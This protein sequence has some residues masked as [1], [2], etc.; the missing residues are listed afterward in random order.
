[1]NRRLEDLR[2]LIRARK[3]DA[4]MVSQSANRRYLSGFT[5][6]AGYLLISANEAVLATDFR[7]LEQAD[8]QAGGFRITRIA[9]DFTNWFP[10][11]VAEMG[12][13]RIGFESE[14]MTDDGYQQL[15]RAA[16]KVSPA[17]RPGL[18][19]TTGLVESLRMVKDLSEMESIAA[20]ARLADEAMEYAV[21]RVFSGMTEK[22]LAWELERFLRERG[23]EPVPFEIIVASG[24]NSARPH[25]RSSDRTIREGEPVVIDLG[26]RVEGY[27]SDLTRTICLGMPDETFRRVYEVVALARRK[28]VDGLRPGLTGG[29]ADALA[30]KVIE[31]AG[32]GE[33]FG[34]GLGHGVGLET[35]ES[36]R[37]GP[38]ARD[39]LSEGMVF[40]VEPGIYI[41]GWGGVRIEDMILLE[42]EGPRVLTRVGKSQIQEIR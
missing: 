32:H 25:A 24:P 23:S 16:R 33:D 15:V 31:D 10:R 39:I 34:H 40:T 11:L 19:R 21:G 3:L 13:R 20:A 42:P 35:H 26:A 7:Y 22:E 30:R 2:H 9:G 1:M 8:E 27:T 5:G 17:A 36:P 28:A 4:L 41:N 18:V 6:S 29:K 37:L 38:T 12:L 14:W